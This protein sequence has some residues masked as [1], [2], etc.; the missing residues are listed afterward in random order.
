LEFLMLDRTAISLDKT[1][2][3]LRAVGEPTRLRLLALLSKSDLNVTDLIEILGQSQPR[4]SRHLKLLAEAGLLERYQEGAWAYFRAV[5]DG[6]GGLIVSGLLARLDAN[7]QQIQRDSQRLD[8]VRSKRAK[9]AELYFSN[10]AENWD[11]LRKI[12]IDE[13]RVEEAMLEMVG[14]TAVHTLLDMGTGTGRLLE[15]FSDVYT[16]AVGVDT[17]RDMLAVAR[18]TIDRANLSSTQVRQ[19]DITML[20]TPNNCFDLVTIHQVLHYLDDPIEAVNEAAKALAP[21]GRLLIVDFAPHTRDDVRSEQAHIRLGFSH[22]QMSAWFDDVGLELIETRDLAPISSAKSSEELLTV[23]LWL[24]RD[25]RMM[26]ADGIGPDNNNIT[27]T[28]TI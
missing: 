14:S 12:H 28:E 22:E 4:I 11:R 18:S 10:N 16:K 7:D 23:T 25:R 19:G 6:S 1:I 5:E 24:A 20:P 3:V 9:Q 8:G 2:D 27:S 13:A 15:L 21:G 17:S 26:I